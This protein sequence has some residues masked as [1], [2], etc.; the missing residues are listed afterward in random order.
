MSA[1]VVPPYAAPSFA[2]R[3]LLP[4]CGMQCYSRLAPVRW[5][6]RSPCTTPQSVHSPVEDTADKSAVRWRSRCNTRPRQPA[7]LSVASET[8]V[9]ESCSAPRRSPSAA[10]AYTPTAHTTQDHLPPHS[11]QTPGPNPALRRTTPAPPLPPSYPV[12]RV[13]VVYRQ[14]HTHRRRNRVPAAPISAAM[15]GR[16]I[17]LMYPVRLVG[18]QLRYQFVLMSRLRH[19]RG[20]RHPLR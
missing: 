1:P 7:R 20:P 18:K 19:Q 15:R 14:H 13:H 8:P 4:H 9:R 11:W 16:A 12:V 5:P 2:A 6:A 17:R 10:A 3:G